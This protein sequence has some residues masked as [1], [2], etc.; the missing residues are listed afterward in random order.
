MDDDLLR[1]IQHDFDN[2]DDV[3]RSY[4]CIHKGSNQLPCQAVI[5]DRL[6]LQRVGQILDD[7]VSELSSKQRE[8]IRKSLLCTAHSSTMDESPG[9]AGTSKRDPV[10]IE[11]SDDSDRLP[12]RKIRVVDD[13][14]QT[15]LYPSKRPRHASLG[16]V[17]D[18][19][20]SA[21]STSSHNP[22]RSA[23]RSAGN[24][25]TKSKSASPTT[26]TQRPIAQHSVSAPLANQ[27]HVAPPTLQVN[28]GHV[29]SQP[30]S[31]STHTDENIL[32]TTPPDV[33]ETA[34]PQNGKATTYRRTS[35][36][37][38]SSPSSKMFSEGEGS[39]L[40]PN[41]IQND[42]LEVLNSPLATA[43]TRGLLYIFKDSK[44]NGRFVK[45][46]ITTDTLQNRR[47]GIESTSGRTLEDYWHSRRISYPQLDRL[48]KLVHTDLKYFQRNLA[49]NKKRSQHEW[50]ELDAEKAR[51]TAAF[52]YKVV[53]EPLVLQEEPP[54]G[55]ELDKDGQHEVNQDHQARLSNWA[56]ALHEP[57]TWQSWKAWY[58]QVEKTPF[59]A[60][61]LVLLVNAM[62]DRHVATLFAA[63][64]FVIFLGH[65][66]ENS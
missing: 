9:A 10:V 7:E 42:V 46:G 6:T 47:R 4:R 24:T 53:T 11:D 54:V 3:P 1:S 14:G 52:W 19:S 17:L 15:H 43:R 40:S 27:S 12:I 22:S 66:M 34:Q 61:G 35:S 64:L 44:T 49:L 5:D 18:F 48:E 41:D 25:P 31:T 50:F 33:Q 36:A 51:E 38:K 23:T 2:P 56:R 20:H 37:Q 28:G 39:K 63:L 21:S 65:H 26:Y 29:L 13:S 59:V 58:K 45:I 60:G 55:Q 8:D 30:S 32:H 16:S 62:W 57:T